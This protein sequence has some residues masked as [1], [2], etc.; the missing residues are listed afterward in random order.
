MCRCSSAFGSDRKRTHPACPGP[1]PPSRAPGTSPS[2]ASGWPVSWRSSAAP[3]SPRRRRAAPSARPCAVTTINEQVEHLPLEHPDQVQRRRA[4]TRAGSPP[5][6][7]MGK[8]DA[9]D[10][11]SRS[12]P[13]TS[14]STSPAPTPVALGAG[15]ASSAS[16]RRGDRSCCGRT[17]GTTT[18]RRSGTARTR[19]ATSRCSRSPY[20]KRFRL[21]A[22]MRAPTAGP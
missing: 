9:S 10:P 15:G 2:R 6:T 22:G 20:M 21:P 7:G 12:T 8:G 4:A 14:T 1:I 3:T 18:A 5:G 11:T 17:T 13:S 16:R 19:S